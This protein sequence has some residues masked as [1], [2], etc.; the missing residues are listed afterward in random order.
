MLMSQM[1]EMLVDVHM[2]NHAAEYLQQALRELGDPDDQEGLEQQ[3]LLL[4]KLVE[5]QLPVDR[6]AAAESLAKCED[7]LIHIPP[8]CEPVS[9]KALKLLRLYVD[10]GTTD[11]YKEQVISGCLLELEQS[12]GR[13]RIGIRAHLL[14]Q[15]AGCRLNREDPKGACEFLEKSRELLEQHCRTQTP[16]YHT[17]LVML[18]RNLPPDDVRVDE[19]LDRAEKLGQ[20]LKGT[21]G[22]ADGR[23]SGKD[24][25]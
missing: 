12:D 23:D 24:D 8:G 10:E 4:V 11:E 5:A 19:Y 7:L 6:K 3:I 21:I 13:G 18:T 22:G 2:P 20:I 14:L 15:L 25:E 16:L 1:A 9:D 17:V